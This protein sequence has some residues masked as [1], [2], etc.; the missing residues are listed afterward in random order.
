MKTVCIPYRVQNSNV[1]PPG[2]ELHDYE[3]PCECQTL[4]LDLNNSLVSTLLN[5]YKI[6]N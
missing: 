3:L 5:F 1:W 6:I 4:N 2:L